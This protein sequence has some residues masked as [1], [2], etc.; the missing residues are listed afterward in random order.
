MNDKL[1]YPI[2]CYAGR[3]PLSVSFWTPPTRGNSKEGRAG[4][5][6]GHGSAI[7]GIGRLRSKQHRNRIL[8]STRSSCNKGCR[9]GVR[10]I[11]MM[12]WPQCRSE[13]IHRSRRK[14]IMER[15]ILAMIFLRPFR[16]EKCDF[17]FFRW[18]F[19]TSPNSSRPAT[20]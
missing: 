10:R 1:N 14:G 8:Y 4:K 15:G 12:S 7:E 3:R 11:A 18:S 20:T 2:F 19:T 6:I 5:A 16:C 9:C 13:R 17:R